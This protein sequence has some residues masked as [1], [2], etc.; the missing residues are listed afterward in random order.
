MMGQTNAEIVRD[1]WNASM[2]QR[3]EALHRKFSWHSP[4]VQ[5]FI[6][7]EYLG[8]LKSKEVLIQYLNGKPIE[9]ALDVGG[10]LG[11]QA[12]VFYDAL[13]VEHFDVLDISDVAVSTGAKRA[14]KEGRN[15]HFAVADLNKEPL[16]DVEY[17]LICA[18]GA[19]HHI[20]NLE[21]L[22]EQINS[23]LAPDGVFYANDY[24]GPSHMQWDDKQLALMN[25]VVGILPDEL[26]R[27]QHRGNNIVS[28]VTRIPLEVFARVD[29]SEGV[30]SA[31]IFDVMEKHLKIEKVVPFGQ[32]L[33]YEVLRGRVQNFDD[34]DAKD[35]AI[36]SLICL[37]EKELIDAGVISSDFN[38]VIAT[39]AA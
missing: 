5:R 3:S 6:S 30:R 8:G 7:A 33:A 13:H 21:F 9:R 19:L 17:D 39:K 28:E 26:N 20:E 24:M 36:L 37:L 4:T 31:D 10:G 27:V 32:T 12:K 16:P 38:F 11:E 35:Q 2:Q 25:A 22:F 18:S 23:R 34:N 15:I 14:K 29:P 1:K